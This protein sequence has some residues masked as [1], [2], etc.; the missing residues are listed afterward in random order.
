MNASAQHHGRALRAYASAKA[1]RSWRAQ[2]ADV[3]R[4]VNFRLSAARTGNALDRARALADNARLWTAM[5]GFLQDPQNALPDGTR[6]GLISIGRSVERCLRTTEP[7]FDFLIAVN[8]NIA[9]GLVA[10]G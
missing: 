7:D 4:Q 10:G 9:A 3:F 2:E 1:T 6:A 5:N 8:E